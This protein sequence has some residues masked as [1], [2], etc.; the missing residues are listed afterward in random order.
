MANEYKKLSEVPIAESVTE[1]A[2]VVIEDAGGIRR[3][4]MSEIGKVK[5][6][7]GVEPDENGNVDLTTEN[8]EVLALLMEENALPT[9]V[10]SSGSILTDNNSTILLG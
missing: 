9:L 10:D 3:T 5:T 4:P 8:E 7:N 2:N 1:A 6:V